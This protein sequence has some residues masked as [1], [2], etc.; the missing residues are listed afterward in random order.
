MAEA[1]GVAA[2]PE[3]DDAGS[4]LVCDCR[5]TGL[6]LVC[7]Q[8][9]ANVCARGRR[10]PKR[11]PEQ[12]LH[13]EPRGRTPAAGGGGITLAEVAK[14]TTETDCWVVVNGEVRYF[15]LFSSKCQ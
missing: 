1:T 8:S 12:A 7:L 13:L 14:H 3:L 11:E 9:P 4:P 10:T 15:Q 5:A 2:R 6:P